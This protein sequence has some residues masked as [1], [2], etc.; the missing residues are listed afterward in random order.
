MVL[1]PDGGPRPGGGRLDG[2][3]H[4]AGGPLRAPGPALHLLQ[5]A[6]RAGHQSADRPAARGA[7]DVA[8]E[9][10][11]A[12]EQPARRDARALPPAQAAPPVPDP[13]GHGPPAAGRAPGRAGR[14]PRHD[15]P[16]RR[17]R[18]GPRTGAGRP[19]PQSRA[20]IAGGATILVLTDRG[21]G[22]RP[23]ADPG[24][25]RRRRAAPPPDPRRPAQRGRHHRRERRAARGDAL[26]AA[27]RLRRQRRLPVPR[28]RDHPRTRRV[29]APRGSGQPR[30]R[31]WTTTSPPSRRGSSRPSARWASRRCAASSAR[32]S[33]RRSG[34][35]S[36]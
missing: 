2:Q 4:A 9:L 24:A 23:R 14:R 15:L 6:L 22:R 13:R 29:R 25:A 12:A 5:A 28:V 32:R 11:R 7:G 26:C 20:A 19:V 18:R 3:R 30:R 33:S 10:H 21:V 17:R 1:S 34:S 31:R 8:D 16:G 36:R 27:L 35:A